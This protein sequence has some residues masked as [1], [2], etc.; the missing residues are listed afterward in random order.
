M[1]SGVRT[2][3]IADLFLAQMLP[4][5]FQLVAT[6]PDDYDAVIALW[7]SCE[8]VRANETREEFDRILERNPGLSSVIRR[9]NELAAAVLCCHDGRRGY[10]YHL[11]VAPQFRKLG[12]GRILV[13]H[14]L[15][16]LQA[17]GIRRCTIFL[18]ADNK[19]GEAFWTRTGWRERT[20]LKAFARDLSP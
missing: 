6:A 9:G 2:F 19:P 7:N 8:G 20:D 14:S 13:E 17:L 10:L 18:I 11:G 16:Q 5:A 4:S 3:A 1:D 15:A 12:L